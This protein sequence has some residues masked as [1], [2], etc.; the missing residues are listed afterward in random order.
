MKQNGA[1]FTNLCPRLYRS[2]F[3]SCYLLTSTR[4]YITNEVNYARKK[5]ISKNNSNDLMKVKWDL[6]LEMA[7]IDLS[8]FKPDSWSD[9]N[10][11]T[12]G[13]SQRVCNKS[14]TV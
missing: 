6:A 9:D 7:A 1:L 14:T 12:I 4:D 5:M 13:K 2:K 10:C 3:I 11:F 8:R